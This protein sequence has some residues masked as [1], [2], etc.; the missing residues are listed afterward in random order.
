MI[1]KHQVDNG[2][3]ILP[4]G[5][6]YPDWAIDRINHFK[7]IMVSLSNDYRDPTKEFYEKIVKALEMFILPKDIKITKALTKPEIENLVNKIEKVTTDEDF[8]IYIW[9][10]MNA[11]FYLST[12][13]PIS[14]DED[15]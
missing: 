13:L 4:S 9:L 3:F 12:V 2:N 7:N 14:I 6:Q 8:A 15:S 11:G 1:E 10:L 5:A